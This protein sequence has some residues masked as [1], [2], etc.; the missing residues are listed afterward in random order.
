MKLSM[1]LAALNVVSIGTAQTLPPSPTGSV[2]CKPHGDHWDCDVPRTTAT[3]AGT[4]TQPSAAT[5]STKSDHDDHDHDHDHSSGVL[6]PS[7]A[8]STGCEPHGDHWHCSGPR[9]AS[10]GSSTTTTSTSTGA[11]SGSSATTISTRPGAASGTPPPAT[12]G[13]GRVGFG[14]AVVVAAAGAFFVL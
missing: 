12:A 14:A 9:T 8:A 10:A 5:T 4:A 3:G 1:M 13:A 6:P 11:V 2:N 7:P